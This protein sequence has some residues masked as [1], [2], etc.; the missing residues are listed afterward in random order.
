MAAVSLCSCIQEMN[1][2]ASFLLIFYLNRGGLSAVSNERPIPTRIVWSQQLELLL[3]IVREDH[4]WGAFAARAA[5]PAH[6]GRP[7]S[8]PA[9]RRGGGTV[10]AHANFKMGVNK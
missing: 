7:S 6:V 2:G 8:T 4:V 1:S 3:K 9:G 10:G 5:F